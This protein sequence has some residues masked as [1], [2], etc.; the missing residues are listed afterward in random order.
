MIA[1]PGSLK[2]N[3]DLSGVVLDHYGLFPRSILH[4]FNQISGK[5]DVITLSICQM[6]GWGYVPVDLVKDE[7]VYF[8]DR[9]LKYVGLHEVVLN[10]P[11]DVIKLMVML[12]A[13]RCAD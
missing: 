7:M 5:G 6:G 9:E 11:S 12:E 3:H 13:K 2:K 4:L 8:D 1:P 10:E